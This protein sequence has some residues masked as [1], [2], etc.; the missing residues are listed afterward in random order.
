MRIFTFLL[1]LSVILLF[2]SISSGFSCAPKGTPCEA[3]GDASAVFI[4]QVVKSE[5]SGSGSVWNAKFQI[6][7]E[8]TFIG[9]LEE[10]VEA[11]ASSG[12]GGYPFHDGKRYLI[13]AYP[14]Q[15]EG[16]KVKS[17]YASYCTRTAPLEEAEEDLNFLRKQRKE[18]NGGRIYGKVLKAYDV[19]YNLPKELWYQP[20]PDLKIE[21]TGKAKKYNLVTDKNGW[22]E[23]E[24][25]VSG[26]YVIG[27]FL[28]KKKYYVVGGVSRK[29][30]INNNGCA[31]KTFYVEK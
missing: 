19:N 6:K 5:F 23:L 21:I 30:Y 3:Y 26:E 29:V 12:F 17:F 8:E 25:L 24:G 2:P 4:G 11:N 20:M 15:K 28:P 1:F 18:M 10:V 16:E 9:E 13:Y 14:K 31:T 22:F 27:V 7:V